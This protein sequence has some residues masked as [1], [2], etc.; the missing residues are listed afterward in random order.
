MHVLCES[1]AERSLN[2]LERHNEYGQLMNYCFYVARDLLSFNFPK[3]LDATD[4]FLRNIIDIACDP[5]V[6]G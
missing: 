6:A 3:C 5:P 1:Q 4:T 2:L